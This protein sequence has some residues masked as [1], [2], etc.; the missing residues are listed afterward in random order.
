MASS[1]RSGEAWN[2]FSEATQVVLARWALL[3]RAVEDEVCQMF[4]SLRFYRFLT[5][6]ARSTGTAKYALAVVARSGGST[7][8]LLLLPLTDAG[9]EERRGFSFSISFHPGSVTKGMSGA[10]CVC[11]HSG[12]DAPATQT[13]TPI[14][15]L[16]GCFVLLSRSS[17]FD[18]S[19]RDLLLL[20]IPYCA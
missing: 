12:M 8:T 1:G 4:L 14:T 2:V 10:R 9:R 18:V 11:R 5:A 20:R 17:R 16:S 7:M 13:G 3:Q 6:T 19:S 15:S